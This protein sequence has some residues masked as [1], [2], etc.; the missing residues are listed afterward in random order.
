MICICV[1]WLLPPGDNPI[2]VNKYYY[3]FA[4]PSGRAVWG[5]VLRPLACCER[6]FESHRGYGCQ[7]V[8]RVVCC[9]VE[10]SA[11]NW[12]RV[13]RISTECG[14]SLCVIKKPREWGGHSPRWG[15]TPSEKE[16]TYVYKFILIYLRCLVVQVLYRFELCTITDHIE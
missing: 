8:V 6:V 12:S 7:S 15:A 10:V 2:A 14:A 9:Q 3:Y 13:Q 5:V 16:N 1:K 11:T 4:D